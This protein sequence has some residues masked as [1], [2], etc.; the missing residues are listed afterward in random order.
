MP[1]VCLHTPNLLLKYLYVEICKAIYL[2]LVLLRPSQ[3]STIGNGLTGVWPKPTPVCK[4]LQQSVIKRLI[5]LHFAGF[6]KGSTAMPVIG[7]IN[8]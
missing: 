6:I 2:F 7:K 8:Y 1:R 3:S 4:T 5:T